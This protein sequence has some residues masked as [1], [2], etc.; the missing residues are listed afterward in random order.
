MRFDIRLYVY[1]VLGQG[2]RTTGSAVSLW[3]I[4]GVDGKLVDEDELVA[5]E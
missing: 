2:N 4:R 5:V 1:S 3:R